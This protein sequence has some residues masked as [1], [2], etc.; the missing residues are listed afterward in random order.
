[1]TGFIGRERFCSLSLIL[2]KF[3]LN[4]LHYVYS[5]KHLLKLQTELLKYVK[6]EQI[7]CVIILSK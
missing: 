6:I 1:M 4:N 5:L 3:H 7:L 2:I